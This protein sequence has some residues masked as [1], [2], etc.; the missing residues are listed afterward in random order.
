[1]AS[2]VNINI[3]Y[4]IPNPCNV[5]RYFGKLC[6]FRTQIITRKKINIMKYENI[7]IHRPTIT[8]TTTFILP[9]NIKSNIEQLPPIKLPSIV[10]LLNDVN[11][12]ID[13]C[14]FVQL[15]LEEGVHVRNELLEV[16][17]SI[18]CHVY[19]SIRDDDGDTG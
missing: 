4:P 5:K 15:F 3:T 13:E 19:V 17:G 7:V 6:I 8:T 11:V 18:L 14:P 2:H 9:R 1:M 16:F 12:I 10:T